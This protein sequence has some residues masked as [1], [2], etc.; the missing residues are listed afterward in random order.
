[1]NWTWNKIYKSLAASEAKIDTKPEGY[2][3]SFAS[4]D[5]PLAACA[6]SS[7]RS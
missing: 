3:D 2:F 6:P 4:I 7:W 1:M 5:P